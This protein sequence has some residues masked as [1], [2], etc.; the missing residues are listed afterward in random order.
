MGMEK[1]L[2]PA[3]KL[4]KPEGQGLVGELLIVDLRLPIEYLGLSGI[5]QKSLQSA[6]NNL[7]SA[8]SGALR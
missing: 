3:R 7:L 4:A 8:G 2:L 1:T 5:L 6:I